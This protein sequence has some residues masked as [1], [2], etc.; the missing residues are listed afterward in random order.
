MATE[1]KNHITLRKESFQQAF[2]LLDKNK[3][4]WIDAGTMTKLFVAIFHY[5]HIPHDGYLRMQLFLDLRKGGDLRISKGE[6]EDI[7]NVISLEIENHEDVSLLSKKL[8][9]YLPGL[10]CLHFSYHGLFHCVVWI[11]SLSGLVVAFYGTYLE[12]QSSIWSLVVVLEYMFGLLLAVGDIIVVLA[13]GWMQY[14]K[15]SLN[16]CN[17]YITSMTI[18]L[19][20]AS[21]IF[22][23][24]RQWMYLLLI[25]RTLC[26]LATFRLF[27]RWILMAQTLVAVLPA[28]LPILNAQYSLFSLFCLLGVQF[29]GGLIFLENPAL[30]GTSFS[31]LGYWSLNFNDYASAVVTTFSLCVV[32]N[33]YIIMDAFVATGGDWARIYFVAFWVFIVAFILNASIAFFVEAVVSH[34]EKIYSDE[35]A[36]TAGGSCDGHDSQQQNPLHIGKRS[37]S[38]YD[39]YADLIQR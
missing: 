39:I 18:C 26:L 24:T 23:I 34:M 1:L 8:S 31:Q 16:R 5:R 27:S 35:M 13:M 2:I 3:Q 21:V 15:E 11:I 30:E 4:G 9:T 38:C 33:W 7:C 36:N 19:I 29:F 17:F 28:A 14:W 25:A 10:S 37:L 22:P 6:F 32:N 12:V 20:I